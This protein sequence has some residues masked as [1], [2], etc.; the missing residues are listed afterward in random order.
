MSYITGAIPPAPDPT[1]YPVTGSAFT[2]IVPGTGGSVWVEVYR[3]ADAPTC[4]PFT[5]TVSE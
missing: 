5:L 4:T 1:V 2:P 3:N